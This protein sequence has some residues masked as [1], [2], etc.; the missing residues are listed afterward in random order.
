L[1]DFGA[2][3]AGT[4]KVSLTATPN[5]VGL[6]TTQCN[7]LTSRLRND[8]AVET[9]ELEDDVAQVKWWSVLSLGLGIR[10]R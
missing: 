2:I 9:A 5:C 1:F 6:T 10:F 8:I 7:S 4:S 3:Y